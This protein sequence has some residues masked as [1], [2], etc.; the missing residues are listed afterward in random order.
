MGDKQKFA[1]SS[2]PIRKASFEFNANSHTYYIQGNCFMTHYLNSY[3]LLIPAGETSFV[4][5]VQLYKDKIKDP[6]LSIDMKNFC[7]QE[8]EH[9]IQHEKFN[10]FLEN[11]GYP[12]QGWVR[13]LNWYIGKFNLLSP[14]IFQISRT[15]GAEHL[16]AIFAYAAFKNRFLDK[17]D[18]AIRNFFI[19]HGLE[20]ME[21]KHVAFDVF[22]TVCPRNYLFR[23]LGYLYAL[24]GGQ[25]FVLIGAI[26]LI[27]DD[28]KKQRITIRRFLRDFI[29]IFKS[30]IS[31]NYLKD[32]F[33]GVMMYFKPSFHPRQ[34]DDQALKDAYYLEIK[35]LMDSKVLKVV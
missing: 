9:K 8:T 29:I 20:E 30:P 19:W 11:C 7:G 21:H 25:I 22:K 13:F 10:K 4:H 16:T 15:A 35:T 18:L 2:F 3:C 24:I 23:I 14:R 26:K 5:A 6:Q 17:G 31:Q 28:I 33:K 12:I 27:K 1:N 34:I 32:I